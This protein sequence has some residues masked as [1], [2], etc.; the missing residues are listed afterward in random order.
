MP[1]VVHNQGWRGAERTEQPFTWIARALT[2]A[3]YAV[4]VPGRRGYGQSGGRTFTEEVGDDRAAAFNS[5]LQAETD[6]ALAAVD[7]VMN[8]MRR[9]SDRPREDRV[10]DMFTCL[11]G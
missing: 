11:A 3:G 9:S 5:R 6:D 1:L 8:W 7:D 4:L 10:L 2:S